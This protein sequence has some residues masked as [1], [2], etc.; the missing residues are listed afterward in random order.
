MK[1]DPKD[2]SEQNNDDVDE[3]ETAKEKT[4]G[5]KALGNIA[6]SLGSMFT[7]KRSKSDNSNKSPKTSSLLKPKVPFLGNLMRPKS[8]A[9]EK[10]TEQSK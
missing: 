5:E 6:T 8:D 10:D 1:D 7:I 2:V 9:K 3:D 4:V